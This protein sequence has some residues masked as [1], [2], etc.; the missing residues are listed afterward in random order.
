MLRKLMQLC[1]HALS[2]VSA[3]PVM[4]AYLSFARNEAYAVRGRYPDENYA[5]EIMQLFTIGLI[6]LNLDGTPKLNSATSLPINTYPTSLITTETRFR[7]FKMAPTIV[8]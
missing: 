4:G 8:I 2:Q 7:G 5:R 6:E 1:A 3:S